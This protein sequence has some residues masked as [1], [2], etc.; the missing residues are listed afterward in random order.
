MVLVISCKPLIIYYCVH[1]MQ[2]QS[3]RRKQDLHRQCD[4][5]KA[6]THFIWSGRGKWQVVFDIHPEAWLRDMRE[7]RLLIISIAV[8]RKLPCS[9]LIIQFIQFIHRALTEEDKSQQ[10]ITFKYSVYVCCSDDTYC[11]EITPGLLDVLAGKI[12]QSS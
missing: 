4:Q 10:W 7:W 6:Y 12:M 9:C 3:V 1:V 8:R 5:N 11:G 2:G